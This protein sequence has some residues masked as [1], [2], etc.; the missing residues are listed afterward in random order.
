MLHLVIRQVSIPTEVV[1][2]E[3]ELDLVGGLVTGGLLSLR[4]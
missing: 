2:G 3:I 1:G 4:V